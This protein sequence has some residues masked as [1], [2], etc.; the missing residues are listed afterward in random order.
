M[1][2]LLNRG[3]Q[4][5]A[6][7]STQVLDRGSQAATRGSCLLQVLYRGAEAS[8]RGAVPCVSQVLGRVP[9]AVARSAARFA[10]HLRDRGVQVSIQTVACGDVTLSQ[11]EKNTRQMSRKKR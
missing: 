9:E 6:R 2:T 10:S 5:D 11:Q 1:G 3:A 8:A 4:A 7:G